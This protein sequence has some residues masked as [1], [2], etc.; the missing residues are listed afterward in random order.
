MI[1][2]RL[3][4]QKD[5]NPS[6]YPEALSLVSDSHLA[7]FPSGHWSQILVFIRIIRD[8][9]KMEMHFSTQESS[10]LLSTQKDYGA[11]GDLCVELIEE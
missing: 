2:I 11:E 9:V 3:I 6:L 10:S 4:L 7:L 8:F 5:K 1:I